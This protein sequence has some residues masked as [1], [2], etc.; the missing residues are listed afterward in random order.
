MCYKQNHYCA[1]LCARHSAKHNAFILTLTLNLIKRQV[2]SSVCNKD[3]ET[4]V[5]GSLLTDPTG[6]RTV[7]KLI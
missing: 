6:G 3:E 7:G 2:Y 1:L 5:E 4:E